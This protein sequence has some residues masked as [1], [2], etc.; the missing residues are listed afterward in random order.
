[1]RE[2]LHF[3]ISILRHLAQRAVQEMVKLRIAKEMAVLRQCG[4]GTRLRFRLGALKFE[5]D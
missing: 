5:R 4:Q 3:L 2:K 1:M